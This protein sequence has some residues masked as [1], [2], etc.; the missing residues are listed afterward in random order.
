[1]T[2]ID[3]PPAAELALILDLPAEKIVRM[4]LISKLRAIRRTA[5]LCPWCGDPAE[6]GKTRCK[7]CLQKNADYLKA[8]RA[9]RLAAGLC[10]R[11]LQPVVP[12]KTL[13]EG[14]QEV[15]RNRQKGYRRAAK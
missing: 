2:L 9:K 12:G 11:C 13:C 14:H 1:M 10:F 3:L 7:T 4:S 6:E 15:A 5:G 8:R